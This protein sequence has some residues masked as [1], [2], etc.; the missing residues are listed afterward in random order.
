MSTFTVENSNRVD[1]GGDCHHYPSQKVYKCEFA[2]CDKM[3]ETFL[4]AWSVYA[5]QAGFPSDCKANPDCKWRVCNLT[6]DSTAQDLANVFALPETTLCKGGHCQ[7]TP[8][9]PSAKLGDIC[10]NIIPMPVGSDFR[11]TTPIGLLQ[12][13]VCN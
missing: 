11:G 7:L 8:G 1:V 3:N 4:V 13:A 10:P 12:N 5:L 6:E 9:T 2:Q